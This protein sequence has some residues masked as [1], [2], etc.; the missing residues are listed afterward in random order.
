MV[1]FSIYLN[2]HVFVMSRNI[3]QGFAIKAIEAVYNPNVNNKGLG[4]TESSRGLLRIHVLAPRQ[5]RIVLFC[6]HVL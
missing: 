3:A 5:N 4:C 2:R 6:L 1:K